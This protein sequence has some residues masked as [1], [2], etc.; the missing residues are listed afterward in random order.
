MVEKVT[1]YYFI[2]VYLIINEFES[3]F[4]CLRNIFISFVTNLNCLYLYHFSFGILEFFPIFHNYLYI[5]DILSPLL[6]MLQI[7]IAN[8]SGVFHFANGALFPEL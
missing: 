5:K 8:S 2:G 7:F 4:L 3:F 1:Q 6:D